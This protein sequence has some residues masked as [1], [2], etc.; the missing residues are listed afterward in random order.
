[1]ELDLFE[2]AIARAKGQAAQMRAAARSR[3]GDMRQAEALEAVAKGQGARDWNTYC[4]VLKRPS[5][6]EIGARVRGRYLKQDITGII[7][8]VRM[9]AGGA[10]ELVIDLD[11]PVD[12]VSFDSFSNFRSRLTVTVNPQGRSAAKTGDGVPHMVIEAID[13]A[14]AQRN[15]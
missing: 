9:I 7:R 3:G 15:R 14:V 1:M 13:P 8:G 4:A 10:A 6:V 12:V 2:A 5:R 11:D